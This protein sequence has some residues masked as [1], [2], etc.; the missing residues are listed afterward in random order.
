VTRKTRLVVVFERR[1]DVILASA[2]IGYGTVMA[3]VARRFELLGR[4][5]SS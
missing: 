2:R 4:E 1:S 5:A 3:E